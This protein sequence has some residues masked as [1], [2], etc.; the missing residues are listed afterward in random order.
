M[1]FYELRTKS[2]QFVTLRGIQKAGSDHFAINVRWLLGWRH[3]DI[4]ATQ[5]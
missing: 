3:H 5:C 1:D 2:I 4:F